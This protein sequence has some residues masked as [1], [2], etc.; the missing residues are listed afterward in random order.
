MVQSE[1]RHY[2][3]DVDAAQ[4]AC[5]WHQ[6]TS[7]SEQKLVEKGAVSPAAQF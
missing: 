3:H 2:S 7:S 4:E 5:Q 1:R 6:E